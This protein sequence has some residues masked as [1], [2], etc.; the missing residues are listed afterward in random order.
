MTSCFFVG[1]SAIEEPLSYEEANDCPDW[2]RAMKE[3]IDA[4]DKNE[5]L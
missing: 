5:I 3:E 4:L 2:E 1:E